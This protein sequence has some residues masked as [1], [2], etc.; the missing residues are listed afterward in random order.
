[1]GIA[2][3][4]GMGCRDNP[5]TKQATLCVHLWDLPFKRGQIP[6]VLT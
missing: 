4:F 1:M 5:D 2:P 3:F 6:E